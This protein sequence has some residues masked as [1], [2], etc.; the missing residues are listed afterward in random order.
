MEQTACSGSS[1]SPG[2][3]YAD[4]RWWPKRR[5]RRRRSQL[6]KEGASAPLRRAALLN[7]FM[8][9]R[10][11]TVQHLLPKV[12]ADW[13]AH[14]LTCKHDSSDRTSPRR[15]P[16]FSGRKRVGALLV[17]RLVQDCVVDR[18]RFGD[19][20]VSG[21]TL[22]V[23]KPADVWSGCIEARVKTRSIRHEPEDAWSASG[24][25]PVR[26]TCRAELVGPELPVEDPPSTRRDRARGP[27]RLLHRRAPTSV[28]TRAQTTR[29]ASR[30][31]PTVDGVRMRG[32][33]P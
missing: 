6:Q 33:A 17:E 24:G 13:N 30:R 5:I 31:R 19:A 15:R 27:A 18:A 8:S 3:S 22:S 29:E 10:S 9:T 20:Q 14:P 25:R 12:L 2:R 11:C 1:V 32:S 7:R 4:S 26:E 16:A 28:V 21:R 23:R